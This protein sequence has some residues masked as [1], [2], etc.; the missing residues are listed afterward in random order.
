MPPRSTITTTVTGATTNTTRWGIYCR[1][2]PKPLTTKSV[3]KKSV[4]FEPVCHVKKHI[5]VNDYTKE[6]IEN[7]WY[8]RTENDRIR[9][10][11]QLEV[12]L[13]EHGAMNDN[14][15]PHF[16]LRSVESHMSKNV[17][18]RMDLRII[19]WDAILDEQEL[20]YQEG[21]YNP[22]LYSQV[23]RKIS[24]RCLQKAQKI[25]QLDEQEARRLYEN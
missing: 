25:A 21:S 8:T 15:S 24:K 12:Q 5:H 16:C 4:T 18:V 17:T 20:Q 13:A 7:T 23:V 6:E 2:A 1:T 3:N 22:K 10:V 11:M 14:D 9:E 19:V